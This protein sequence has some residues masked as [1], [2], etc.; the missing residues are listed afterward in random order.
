MAVQITQVSSKADVSE[1]LRAMFL[2]LLF[3]VPFLLKPRVSWYQESHTH[4]H[5]RNIKC[6]SISRHA[7]IS[8]ANLGK[9]LFISW[10]LVFETFTWLNQATKH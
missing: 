7:T 1:H 10:N 2:I 4:T 3:V 6:T 5:T 9:S 8:H